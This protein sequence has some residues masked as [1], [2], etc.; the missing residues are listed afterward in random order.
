MATPGSEISRD[1]VSSNGKSAIDEPSSPYFLHHSD[2][3]GIVLVS[4]H[5]TGDNYASWSR[6]MLISLSVKNKLG[7]I[8]G[9]ITKPE[10]NDL[11][12]LNSWI[13]N[14]NVVISWIL[15]SISKEISSSVIFS[16]SACEIWL[17]LKDR[18]QQRNG[19]RI[20]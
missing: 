5:L 17:D 16:V 19:P 6:A 9:S 20:F 8:D 11:N 18:F 10:G 12:L 1:S 13:R 7:F 3:P 14:N 4:Q 2:G 15:N